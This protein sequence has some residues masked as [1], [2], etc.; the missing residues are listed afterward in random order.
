MALCSR[1]G[2]TQA[3]PSA[4]QRQVPE[5]EPGRLEKGKVSPCYLNPHSALPSLGHGDQDRPSGLQQLRQSG[6]SQ[7]G[8]GAESGEQGAAAR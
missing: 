5:P 1:G 6:L 3:I 8:L 2:G 7:L 4:G